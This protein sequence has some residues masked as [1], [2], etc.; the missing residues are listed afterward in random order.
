MKKTTK[1]GPSKRRPKK[2]VIDP[3]N[4]AGAQFLHSQKRALERY[5][6][7]LTK[8]IYQSIIKKIRSGQGTLIAKQS[9]RVFVYDVDLDQT[10]RVVYDKSRKTIAT[11]LPIQNTATK[12]QE[13]KT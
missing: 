12:P 9:L 6:I 8:E 2:G 3:S 10:Y 11:F 5:G 13:T 4:K 7:V 1:K